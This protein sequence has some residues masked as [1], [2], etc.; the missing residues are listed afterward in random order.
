MLTQQEL[1]SIVH[2][3]CNTGIFTWVKTKKSTNIGKPAGCFSKGTGYHVICIHYNQYQAHRLAWLYVYGKFPDG[4]IDHINQ[5]RSDNRIANLRACTRGQNR[6]NT[7]RPNK[8][9]TGIKG[10]SYNSKNP[11]NP[12][13]ARVILRFKKVFDKSFATAKEAN[14]AAIEARNRF[15]GEFARHS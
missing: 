4:D 3:D 10:V 5:V 2:Y 14:E 13:R 8:S 6:L 15:Q 9:N 7:H 1:K 11:K 12:W